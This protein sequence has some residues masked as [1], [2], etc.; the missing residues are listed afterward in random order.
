[1]DLRLATRYDGLRAK[2]SDP[3]LTA[4]NMSLEEIANKAVGLLVAQI[5]G[6]EPHVMPRLDRIEI[7]ERESSRP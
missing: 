5:E 1:A 7:V 6:A 3:P 2:L 4:V